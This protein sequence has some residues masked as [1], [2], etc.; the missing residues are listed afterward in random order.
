MKPLRRAAGLTTLLAFGLA[1]ASPHPAAAALSF[2]QFTSLNLGGDD[3]PVWSHDGSA[4]FYSSRATGFPYIFRKNLGDAM[5]ATGARLTSWTFDEYQAAVSSDDA[6]VTLCVGDS[7]N[8]R[9]FYRCPATGGTP[10]TKMTYGPFYDIDPDWYGS[11]SGKIAFSSNR[12]GAGFQ[13]WTLQPNGTLPA[14]ALTQV[15]D[16]GHSDSHPSFSQDGTKLVFS[17][18]R[19]GG[20]QLFVSTWNGSTWG[21]PAP[22]TTGGGAKTCPDWSAN[23]LQ[24]AYESTNGGNTELRVIQADGLNDRL[25]TSTGSYDARPGWANDG[26]KL[27][28]VS[29]RSGAKYIWLADGLTTPTA[30]DTW[31]RVKAL[32][33][34]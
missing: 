26:N 27:A 31:G 8:S 1:A 16:A 24:I 21:V 34:R 20:T 23:G 30:S 13:I 32:Y 29:D 6:W 5:N 25:V 15:T 17:S 7:I 10:L 18:D 19:G 4:V 22:L 12:G 9:H 14:L 2:S 11:S 33:R 28:F 3:A